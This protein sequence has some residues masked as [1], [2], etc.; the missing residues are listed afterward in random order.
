MGYEDAELVRRWQDGDL[1][2]FEALVRRWEQPV[3]RFL[4]RFTGRGEAV[5][6]LCQEVFLRAYTAGPRY[7]GTAAFSTWLFRIAINL[8]RDA[9]RRQQRLARVEAREPTADGPA[10]DVVCERN[11]LLDLLEQAIAELPEPQRTVLL[12]HHYERLKFEEIARVTGTPASTLKSRFAAALQRLRE[13]L[14]RLG[15]GPEEEA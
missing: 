11:E 15:V 6:D 9:G 1:A 14:P 7:R 8:A 3:A 13:R 2:A 10:A 12:L 5:A 4:L